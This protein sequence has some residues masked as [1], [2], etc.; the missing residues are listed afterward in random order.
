MIHDDVPIVL[1]DDER[2][3]I[4]DEHDP[5][6]AR[7]TAEDKLTAAHQLSF[8][9][10]AARLIDIDAARANRDDAIRSHT[11]MPIFDPTRY[12]REMESLDAVG[13][14]IDAFIAFREVIDAHARS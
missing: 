2:A 14:V 12:M 10:T 4:D 7:P 5:V 9:I 11:T 3:L 1:T 8:L 13:A 6:I